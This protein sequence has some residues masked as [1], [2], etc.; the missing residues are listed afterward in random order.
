MPE[1]NWRHALREALKALRVVGLI[2]LGAF[3]LIHG[4][5]ILDAYFSD[6][7]SK[8]DL[9][10]LD[11][12]NIRNAL[13]LYFAKTGRYP[14]TDEGLCPLVELKALEF[15]PQDPWGRE[16]LYVNEDG[17]PVITTYGQD[18]N[19]GGSF[20]DEDVSIRVGDSR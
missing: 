12:M 13:K 1:R 17:N 18:G 19:P 3:G 20:V 8:H 7:R 5:A 14:G 4:P 9:A 15:F 2:V 16:Y 11:L 10:R 6:G